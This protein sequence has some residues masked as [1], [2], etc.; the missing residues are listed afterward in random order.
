MQPNSSGSPIAFLFMLVFSLGIY[1]FYS[2]CLKRIVEK[3]GHQPG[4]IIWIPV[5]QLIPLFRVARMNPWLI[6]L[7]AIPLANLIVAIM[8][9][10]NVLK[11]LGRGAGMVVVL[12][13]FGV[14]YI[15]YLA[16][17]GSRRSV[18]AMA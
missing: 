10:V 12:L 5:L 8:L 15:P 14:V 7:L 18:P 6:L 3:A 4:G 16:L 9:W 13:L 11:V 2:Y 1:L 17:S